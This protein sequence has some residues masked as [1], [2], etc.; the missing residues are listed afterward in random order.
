ML[1]LAAQHFAP[2]MSRAVG[3]RGDLHVAGGAGADRHEEADRLF[4]GGAYGR[5]DD[6]HLHLQ[7]P[8]HLRRAVPD[9]VARRR[10]G[11]ACSCASAS[12]TTASTRARSPVT[13]GWRTACR[14][15]RWRSCCS[16]WRSIGLPGTAGF[17]GEFLVLVGALQVNFWLALLGSMGMILGA[18]YMLYLYRRVIFGASRATTCKPSSTCRRARSRSSRRWS[19]SR[20]GWASIPRSF[21]GFFDAAVRRHGRSPPGGARRH[22]RRKLGGSCRHELEPGPAGDRAGVLGM[23]ILIFGVLQKRDDASLCTMLAI[24]ALLLTAVLVLSGTRGVGY[25]GLFV[26]DAFALQQAADPVGSAL[27][28]ILSL[29]YNRAQGIAPLRVPG[30]DAVLHRRHDDDGVGQQPDDAVSRARAAIAGDLRAGGL[31]TRRAAL[32]RGRAEIF[33]ARRAGLR[34]AAVRHLA[35]LRLLRHHGVRPLAQALGDPASGSPGW[36]SASCSSSPGW[37][38]RS[39]RCRSTC[40]R[41]MC[42]R[43]RRR[44]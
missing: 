12:S 20:S 16:P 37:R 15:T 13:A 43:A 41:R 31:R 44:R 24:G 2:L 18:G 11:R 6:R 30:A 38:S 39:P 4:V 25:H 22:A 40:G 14:P 9:A 26:G 1:P 34:A 23:A 8:G 7:R 21:T 27:G 19:S 17:V 32:V 35:G 3:D 42:T 10:L 29:D 5:G 28:A 33:R 36:W